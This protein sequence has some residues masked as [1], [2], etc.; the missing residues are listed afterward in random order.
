MA[1]IMAIIG[2][3][4]AGAIIQPFVQPV[5]DMIK[6]TVDGMTSYRL[7]IRKMDDPCLYHYL[8]E[9]FSE[10]IECNQVAPNNNNNEV[11]YT[12]GDGDY[13]ITYS[14]SIYGSV[15]IYININDNVIKLSVWRGDTIISYMQQ[16]GGDLSM[17]QR[18]TDNINKKY[19]S[20]DV[21]RTFY[22]MKENNWFPTFRRP[23]NITNIN[24]SD[25]MRSIVA[26][27]DT[28]LTQEEEYLNKGYA[29][30]K[31][32]LLEGPTGCGKTKTIEYISAKHN[33]PIYLCNINSENFDD[34]LLINLLSTV[35]P[36]S[37]IVF[38]EFEKQIRNIDNDSKVTY[39]GIL[40]SLD[41]P[42]RLNHGVIVLLT[43]NDTS[44]IPNELKVPL[45]R[46]G[47]IDKHYIFE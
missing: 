31:G 22:M 20:P 12:L 2:G 10:H 45:L 37:L 27:V 14:D 8:I 11:T 47:R 5:F 36:K 25:D 13:N 24:L 6:N 34:T 17:L 30:K 29:Y 9:E 38:E 39:A 7:T 33:R 41:G 46:P 40:S 1:S 19:N 43:A 32:Y 23:L 35:P 15:T 44:D 28:F 16:F 26:D 4:I 21:S 3:I 18:Y 42:Q